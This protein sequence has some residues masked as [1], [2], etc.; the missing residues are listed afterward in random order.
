MAGSLPVKNRIIMRSRF[1]I[2]I[3]IS[4]ILLIIS[5]PL[6][7][8]EDNLFEEGWNFR[9]RGYYKNLFMYQER[10]EFYSRIYLPP[11]D[12]KLVTDLNRLRVS[13]EVNYAES[14][15][16]HA[17]A[18]LE[19]VL[20]NYSNSD[21]FDL[22]FRDKGY[23]DPVKP[24][25]EFAHRENLYVRG[26]IQNFYAKMV[27]GKFTGT[28]GRQQVRFGSSRLWNPLDLMNPFSP[29]SVE[30]ADEQKGTD[31][32]RLDWY[33]G[34]STELTCVAAPKRREDSL[35]KADAGSGNYIARMK[36]GVKAFDAALLGGYTAK[37]RNAGAD[38]AAE[39]YDG[40]L[41][42]VFLYSDPEK[43]KEYWQCGA[44]YEY[45]FQC[46]LYFLMEYFF[47]SL[48]V[49]DD[50]EL[51][52]ALLHYS[53]DGIDSS[54]YHILSNRMI[55]YNSHYLS[56]AAGYDFHPLLRG[57]VFSIYDFQGRG[58]FL[59]G[60]LKFNAL[61]NLDITVGIISAFI[62]RNN[63]TSDFEV[64]NKEPVYY[65]SLQYYF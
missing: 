22:L 26:K 24:E 48:P 27:A 52:E 60:V 59:N 39:V 40:L 32:L 15:T 65:A 47:N 56:I 12:K 8:E 63:R 17:D 34:E 55:T 16:L 20:S 9:F 19:A 28:A 25:A 53:A 6:Y 1:C 21:E 5:I 2:K 58:V 31:A 30:G 18:D 3:I 36:S 57:E 35:D 51:Q 4:F 13:P 42:G 41:T 23:N 50:N 33:P 49:N 10:D 38:F 62:K 11:E 64:Y 7:S 29:L 54:N 46:G 14:F 43:G 45:T 61:E 37:R 44:G